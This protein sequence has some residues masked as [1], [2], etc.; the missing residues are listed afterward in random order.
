MT[1]SDVL[2]VLGVAITVVSTM[3]VW[4]PVL[5]LLAAAAACWRLRPTG[6]HRG[7]RTPLRTRVRTPQ[8]TAPAP[9]LPRPMTCADTCPDTSAAPRPEYRDA[10]SNPH[11]PYPPAH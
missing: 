2:A 7:A 8:D 9:P 3:P 6:R 4:G 10:R 5:L 11:A 1:T